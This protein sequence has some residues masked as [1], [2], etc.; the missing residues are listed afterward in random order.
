VPMPPL[1]LSLEL[2]AKLRERDAGTISGQN[3]RVTSRS[4]SHQLSY[5]LRAST[6][7]SMELGYEDRDDE[8]SLAS[9]SSYT[10]TPTFTSS[11]GTKLHVT[12]FVKFTYTNVDTEQGKPLFFLEEGLREDWSLLGQYR[13]T[14]NVSFGVNY[15]GRR[16]KDF[17]G[18]VKTVHA[19]KMESRAYF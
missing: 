8:V 2:A 16:E 14:R 7:L 17:R 13:I 4:V 11:I 1:T 19:L 18:E 12:T 10:V 6:R 5:R 3:Y 15:T 9:Q